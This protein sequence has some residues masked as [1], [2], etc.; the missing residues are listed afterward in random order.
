MSRPSRHEPS[1]VGAGPERGYIFLV[2]HMRSYSSLLGHLLAENGEVDGYGE[3]HRSYDNDDDLVSM[4][5]Q[6]QTT[7][8]RPLTGRFLFD[9]LLHRSLRLAP[10]IVERPDTKVILSVRSPRD[11][12]ASL[13]TLGR[14]DSSVQWAKKQSG[15][16]RHYTRRMADIEQLAEAHPSC[17]F[18]IADELIARPGET[19]SEIGRFLSLA[20]PLPQT[21][22]PKPRTGAQQFG[23]T[24]EHIRSGRLQPPTRR[25]VWVRPSVLRQA[26]N[27]FDQLL[28]SQ[29]IAQTTQLCDRE[30]YL[31]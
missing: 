8:D 12:L 30:P 29:A 14:N 21:Y 11:T 31:T 17:G 26:Q 10:E 27:A 5:H 16:L 1:P 9:K 23:D 28:G 22:T 2:S 4:G 19:L 25:R 7:Y 6:V 3:L 13:I 18:L 15:A 24:S 20:E